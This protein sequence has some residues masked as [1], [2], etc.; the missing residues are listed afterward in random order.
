MG[1]GPTLGGG[2][3][4][5]LTFRGRTVRRPTWHWA[6]VGHPERQERENW[7]S[8]ETFA[9]DQRRAFRACSIVSSTLAANSDSGKSELEQLPTSPIWLI[10][11]GVP[12]TDHR[13]PPERPTPIAE[14]SAGLTATANGPITPGPCAQGPGISLGRSATRGRRY[15][16]ELAGIEQRARAHNVRGQGRRT[17]KT[18]GS[19][20]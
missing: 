10:V 7:L 20:L 2:G 3:P 13:E 4:G 18:S 5:V 15:L 9:Q 17:T 1:G 11:K 8:G 14:D 12:R 19:C 6:Y 16:M